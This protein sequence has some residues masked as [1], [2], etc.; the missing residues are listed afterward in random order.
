MNKRRILKRSL[1]LQW[2]W[3]Y[4]NKMRVGEFKKKIRKMFNRMKVK[5]N[6]NGEVKLG[7]FKK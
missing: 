5:R 7:I 1:F 2:F 4:V 6:W 3:G